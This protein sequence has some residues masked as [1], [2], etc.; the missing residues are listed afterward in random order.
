M[1]T[2]AN[3]LAKAMKLRA[4]AK[5]C[6]ELA[7]LARD[8]KTNSQYTGLAESY[9]RLARTQEALA[10]QAPDQPVQAGLSGHRPA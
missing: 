1:G 10:Q 3:Y 6:R 8:R 4:R 7:G 9:E 5:E 2:T